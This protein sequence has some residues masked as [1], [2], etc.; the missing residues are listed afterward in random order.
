MLFINSR[1]KGKDLRG[2]VDTE[3]GSEEFY[4]SREL[5]RLCRQTGLRIE[6]VDLNRNRVYA[7][8]KEVINK[9]C[10][11]YALCGLYP[12]N[13]Y[14]DI[15]KYSLNALD[16]KRYWCL[17]F[18]RH[19]KS[20]LYL[21]RLWIAD[22][23]EVISNLANSP[24]YKVRL[25][26]TIKG[27]LSNC[28]QDCINLE[29]ID[30]STI[31]YIGTNAFFGCCKLQGVDLSSARLICASAFCDC[32]ELRS[33]KLGNSLNTLGNGIFNNCESLVSVELPD[34]LVFMGH[35][36]FER[37]IS[38]RQVEIPKNVTS[39]GSW[40]F[41]GCK[42]LEKVIFPKKLDFCYWSTWF[43]GCHNLKEIDIS[44]CE[45]KNDFFRKLDAFSGKIVLPKGMRFTCNGKVLRTVQ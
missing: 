8:A 19:D 7:V 31:Q 23:V 10:K 21:K 28:F 33:V 40:C 32:R 34:S 16:D 39:V 42:S 18:D 35:S 3:D 45:D 25:P 27:I 9:Q 17:D 37:C 11:K 26:K 30:C 13:G 41:S 1:V 15:S 20:D 24:F 12:S 36:C 22:G 43:N 4:S 6:G 44:R 38:L 5:L 29:S 14:V 2:V